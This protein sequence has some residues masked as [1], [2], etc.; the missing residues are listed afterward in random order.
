MYTEPSGQQVHRSDRQSLASPPASA[1]VNG[2]VSR[3]R[4]RLERPPLARGAVADTAGQKKPVPV[5]CGSGVSSPDPDAEEGAS[6]DG[7]SE[8]VGSLWPLPPPRGDG[9]GEN[10]APGVGKVGV[11]KLD[12]A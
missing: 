7:C 4:C 6:G 10:R 8:A 2:G 3:C 12:V 1:V 9:C 11:G 5:D